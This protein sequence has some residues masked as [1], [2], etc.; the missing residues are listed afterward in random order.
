MASQTITPAPIPN[1]FGRGN[2][3]MLSLG[4]ADGAAGGAVVGV[5]GLGPTS[6]PSVVPAAGTLLMAV[7]GAVEAG[8]IEGSLTDP[9]LTAELDSGCWALGVVTA[10]CDADVT[11]AVVTGTVV[12]ET[13]TVAVG[14]RDGDAGGALDGE[15]RGVDFK[16]FGSDSCGRLAAT[17]KLR[18]AAGGVLLGVVLL[19]VV[20]VDAPESPIVTVVAPVVTVMPSVSCGADDVAEA[21]PVVRSSAFDGDAVAV[22]EVGVSSELS[23]SS[24]LGIAVGVVDGVEASRTG[25]VV[26]VDD[27]DGLADDSVDSAVPAAAPCVPI[28][29]DT[30][31]N[32]RPAATASAVSLCTFSC[33]S[34]VAMN[35]LSW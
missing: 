1:E 26:R 18:R 22:G 9:P 32:S 30:R 21:A 16:T 35:G 17:A 7:G 11:G 2:A 19:G 10:G 27:G 29:R 24:A 13:G 34:G 14:A 31:P 20:P 23:A 25:R 4:G 28:V 33:R 15:V 6:P 3:L 12:T 5:P 8:P